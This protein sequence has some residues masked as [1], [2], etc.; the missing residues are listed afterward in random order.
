MMIIITNM[1]MINMNM[2][3]NVRDPEHVQLRFHDAPA[4]LCKAIKFSAYTHT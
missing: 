3:S 4:D 2:R 1:M